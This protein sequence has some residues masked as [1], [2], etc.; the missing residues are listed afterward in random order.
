MPVEARAVRV[1][2]PGGPSPARPVRLVRAER[3]EVP[4]AS[5]A[6]RAN[7]GAT[8]RAVRLALLF[9]TGIVLVYAALFAVAR[10]G[11]YSGSAALGGELGIVAGAAILI[12]AAGVV[13]ALGSAPRRVEI[14]ERATIVVGRFGRRYRYPG[15]SQL[16]VVVL[17]RFPIGPLT[18]VPLASVEIRGGSSRRSFLVEEQLFGPTDPPEGRSPR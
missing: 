2:R 6:R 14:G 3:P 8:R 9:S 10:A 15:R 18:P 17:Q 11:P 5:A 12:G 1:A 7:V 16:R 13:A 4:G